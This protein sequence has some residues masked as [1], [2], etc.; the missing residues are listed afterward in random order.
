MVVVIV[1]LWCLWGI[2]LRGSLVGAYLYVTTGVPLVDSPVALG[3]PLRWFTCVEF[4][5]AGLPG[6][7][8]TCIPCVG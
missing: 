7:F 1:L 8:P 5:V 4:R 6:A 2:P 3:F